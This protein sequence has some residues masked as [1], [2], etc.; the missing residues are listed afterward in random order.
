MILWR[1]SEW[2]GRPGMGDAVHPDMVGF[3]V[4]RL[5]EVWWFTGPLS[6]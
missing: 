4:C 1:F 2:K 6:E 3:Y 5:D